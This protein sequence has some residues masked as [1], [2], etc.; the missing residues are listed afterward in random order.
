MATRLQSLQAS[1][2]T[3]GP[4]APRRTT[5]RVRFWSGRYPRREWP[6]TVQPPSSTGRCLRIVRAHGA[7]NGTTGDRTGTAKLRSTPGQRR[8]DALLEVGPGETAKGGGHS[9]PTSER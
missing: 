8:R 7:W 9:R 2:G 3:W 5:D 1:A 4:D 6:A